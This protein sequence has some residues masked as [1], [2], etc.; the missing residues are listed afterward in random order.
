[1]ILLLLQ[2]ITVAVRNVGTTGEDLF[3][4]TPGFVVLKAFLVYDTSS[5]IHNVP[6][7]N[8]M[9]RSLC[10]VFGL[11]FVLIPIG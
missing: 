1:M 3:D 4:V 11:R 10:N 9:V 5:S 8:D 6:Y 2:S 7:A